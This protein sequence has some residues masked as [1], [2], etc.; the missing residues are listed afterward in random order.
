MNNPPSHD[1]PLRF[2][3]LFLSP[4]PNIHVDV[5]LIF[6][7]YF[8]LLILIFC[9]FYFFAED[10]G[11]QSSE[12]WWYYAGSADRSGSCGKLC[13]SFFLFFLFFSDRFYFMTFCG[14]NFFKSHNSYL[15]VRVERKKITR[16]RQ[17][18]PVSQIICL[19]VES[20]F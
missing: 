5:Y 14:A 16:A 12:W 20:T 8:E 17:L 6:L 3:S 11:E 15:N 4:H 19:I 2:N 1:N 13:L 9:C 7:V 18:L 10:D